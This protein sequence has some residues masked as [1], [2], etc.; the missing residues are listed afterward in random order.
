[1]VTLHH[2]NSSLKR[3]QM[4]NKKIGL[5]LVILVI[6]V[7]GIVV[8]FISRP[9]PPQELLPQTFA[10]LP[11]RP[12]VIAEFNHSATIIKDALSFEGLSLESAKTIYSVTFSPIDPS[13]IAS[14]NGNGTVK[15]W[16]INNTKEPI[17]ILRQP[18]I[19]PVISFSPTG[20]LLTC[21]GYGTLTIWDVASGTK[22]NSPETSHRQFA[23]S[24]D[25]Q[26]LATI[27]D[28]RKGIHEAGVKIWDIRNPKKITEIATINIPHATKGSTCAV[29]ISS[30]GKWIAA[31]YSNGT[32]H[33]WDLQ[34]QQL[35]KSIETPLYLMDYLKFSPNNKY[36]VAGGRDQEGYSNYSVKGYIMWE[37][38][39]WQRKGEVLRGNVEN[40]VF[41]PD[42][43]MCVGTNDWYHYG[44]GVELWSTANG[45]PISSLPT[46]ATDASFSQD[47]NL[48][49]TGGKDGIVRVWKLT[50]S[51][52][53]L[54][55]VRNDVV[56]L[57]YY[58]PKD[59]EPSPN[60]TQKID[61]TIRE[62]QKH[63]AD[64]MERHGFGRKTFTFETDEN[65][66]AKIYRKKEIPTRAHDLQLNDIWLV[67]VDHDN[68]LQSVFIDNLFKRLKSAPAERSYLYFDK[69]FTFPIRR[70]GIIKGKIG[71]YDI[72]GF[73]GDGRFAYATK[74]GFDW[75][76][77]VY[78]LKHKFDVLHRKHHLPKY[79]PNAVKRVFKGINS[80]MPWSKSWVKL[81]KCE[82]EWL[83]RSRFFNPNQSFFDKRPEIEMDVLKT[84]T[85]S[86]LFQFTAA[87]ED[88]I[89][90]LQLFVTE[91]SE[92]HYRLHK[93]QGCQA[94][95]G[96]KKATVEFEI[97]DANIEEG[98]IRMIDMHGNIA[99]RE[100]R[101]IEKTSE[102]D[103][104]P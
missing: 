81:S 96:K 82:A 24:S 68:D 16:N 90:Q 98:E 57:I 20:K 85:D 95:N 38:P 89:H 30:D 51:Q 31:G 69:T 14:V 29:D 44:R 3:K 66:K 23:F 58:L 54:D 46:E 75:R 34:T 53:D 55:K 77:I 62:V 25:G 7:V 72:K 73:T 92:K 39:S 6:A 17:R 63:Y 88:G 80:I 56:R 97:A 22:I 9:P 32:I 71:M 1:M 8:Y 100:F 15:L 52:L 48:L 91:K 37:L 13:L 84:D 11:G 60:I 87:D 12:K 74:K 104:E 4:K 43:K 65:G 101:I 93:L 64:E 61:E 5:L 103:K 28:G 76:L 42:G 94:L 45:A 86:R 2:V 59:K 50:Q 49:V 70:I 40:L 27:R 33:V 67:F 41:S 83:D 36:M 21:A 35:V 47:G 26:K 99:S 19:F 102:P 10:E 79:E 18:G 78:S